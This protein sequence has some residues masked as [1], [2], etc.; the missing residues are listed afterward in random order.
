TT[1]ELGHQ[2]WNALWLDFELR[3]PLNAEQMAT[4]RSFDGVRDLQAEGNK[5]SAQ[6]S[7]AEHIPAVIAAVAANGGAIMRVNPREHSLE[8]IYFELQRRLETAS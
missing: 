5:L 4:L 8:D 3:A 6:V 2:I 1:A 7:D